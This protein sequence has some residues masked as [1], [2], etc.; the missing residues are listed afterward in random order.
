MIAISVGMARAKIRFTRS[1]VAVRSAFAVWKRLRGHAQ[2]RPD[3]PHAGDL[4]AQHLVDP[5]DFVLHG[6][7]QRHHHDEH[8]ADHHRHDRHCHCQ[9]RGQ[10]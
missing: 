2:E 9:Q 7:E 4:L 3:H 10:R 6:P 8:G 1:A 5:V